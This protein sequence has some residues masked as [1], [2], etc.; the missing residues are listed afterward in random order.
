MPHSEMGRSL[1]GS[2]IERPWGRRQVFFENADSEPETSTEGGETTWR[3]DVPATACREGAPRLMLNIP[4]R[5]SSTTR[6]SPSLSPE[7]GTEGDA[8]PESRPASG[9]RRPRLALKTPTSCRTPH[10]VLSPTTPD[11]MRSDLV[12]LT[13]DVGAILFDFD[14]TLTASP[15][16]AAQRCQKQVELVE[17]A[18]ML[19]PRL[20]ALHEAGFVLGIISKS[21]RMTIDS[22]LQ[23]ARLAEYFTGPLLG[24]AVGFEGKAGFIADLVEVGELHDLGVSRA[25]R[26]LLVD[27][28][29]RELERA[30]AHGI[31]TYAAPRTGGLQEEDFDAIFAHLGLQALTTPSSARSVSRKSP[32]SRTGAGAS[33]GRPPGC[34][35]PRR[36]RTWA[37]C[38]R[39]PCEMSPLVRPARGELADAFHVGSGVQM[40]RTRSQ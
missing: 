36:T 40:A 32:T 10:Y 24:K 16:D 2:V 38:A 25:C 5:R 17:R 3:R 33:D 6:L 39:G 4:P 23:E 35:G 18:P 12:F 37:A 31:Q 7:G 8:S 14:G 22:A 13:G 21:S 11:P 20:R 30:R 15:G 34:R 28:D 1:A 26:V 19:A 27:D 9:L 29:V